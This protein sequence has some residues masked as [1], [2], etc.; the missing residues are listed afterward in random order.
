M[1]FPNVPTISPV[2]SLNR[3]AV[4]NL[5]LVSVA[6][7]ELSSAHL[8]NVEAEKLQIVLGTTNPGNLVGVT[9]T[10]VT[11]LLTVNHVVE[12]TLRDI[13][14][15]QMLLQFKLEDILDIAPSSPISEINPSPEGVIVINSCPDV[16]ANNTYPIL[17]KVVDLNGNPLRDVS[18]HFSLNGGGEVLHS[19]TTSGPDGSFFTVLKT[20]PTPGTIAFHAITQD[21]N[22]NPSVVK[23]ITVLPCD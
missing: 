1:S 10:S 21:L 18:I 6:L 16:C 19:P 15:H 8:L 23:E 22:G 17:G 20:P 5:L 13:I 7:E 9:V 4:R 14:K 3:A 11:Q 2:I 12:R